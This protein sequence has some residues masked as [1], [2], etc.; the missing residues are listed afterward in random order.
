MQLKEDERNVVDV[1]TTINNTALLI[2]KKGPTH[3]N[4]T[5]KRKKRGFGKKKTT[6]EVVDWF[7]PS[8]LM[9]PGMYRGTGTIV[10]CF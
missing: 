8:T 3:G 4:R 10:P 2:S 9:V 7:L 1:Y 5:L 6:Y